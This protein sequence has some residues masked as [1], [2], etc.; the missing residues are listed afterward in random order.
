MTIMHVK[1]WNKMLLEGCRWAQL[2]L[3][4]CRFCKYARYKKKEKK[5]EEC[6]YLPSQLFWVMLPETDNTFWGALGVSGCCDY[7]SVSSFH[8]WFGLNI[9][10]MCTLSTFVIILLSIRIIY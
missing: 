3:R 2:M 8:S 9:A 6:S 10:H 4:Q 5:K 1:N 7:S